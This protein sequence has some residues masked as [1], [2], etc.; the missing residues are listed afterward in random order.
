MLPYSQLRENIKLNGETFKLIP[1]IPQKVKVVHS[2]HIYSKYY[3]K[4]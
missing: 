2:L 1:L 3:L 4:V